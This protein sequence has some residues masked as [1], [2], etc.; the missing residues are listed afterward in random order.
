M[1]AATRVSLSLCWAAVSFQGRLHPFTHLCTYEKVH[2]QGSSAH[3]CAFM[4]SLAS[5][6]GLTVQEGSN[7][8]EAHKEPM[9]D[10]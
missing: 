1:P 5:A 7:P 3:P 8:N 2:P 6:T 10:M 9:L 4:V